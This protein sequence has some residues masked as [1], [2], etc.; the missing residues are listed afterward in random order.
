[1]KQHLSMAK[2]ERHKTQLFYL[3]VIGL[4]LCSTVQTDAQTLCAGQCGS[5]LAN[6]SCHAS[7]D[8]L[9]ICCPDYWRFCLRTSPQSGTLMGGKDFVI[10]NNTFKAEDNITC[11]FKNSI[12]T[13]GYVDDEK[14][15]HCISPLLYENGRIPFELS[16]D[17][18]K[19]YLHQGTW[20]AVHHGKYSPLKKAVLHNETKWQY[21]GTPGVTGT[22]T[23]MWNTSI[24]PQQLVRIELWGYQENGLPYSDS[25]KGVW[26]YLYSL[27][28]SVRNS[29]IFTFTPQPAQTAYLKWEI[30]MLRITGQMEPEGAP[31][32]R[33]LWSPSHALAWHLGEDF[34]GNSAAWAKDKCLKWVEL[35]KTLPDFLSE[36][37]DC[38][39]TM[40]QSRADTGRFHPDYGCDIEHGSMCTYHPGAVHCVRA[41]QGSL[42][43]G[44]GQQCCY[45][46]KGNQILTID[47]TG[48]S[49]PD[50]GHD[51]GSPPY[52][53]PPRVP[54][55]SHGLYDVIS[56]Y[57]C[58][59]W[60]DN[61]QQYTDLRP[62]SDCRTYRPP[63]V[64]TAFGDPHLFTF[65][66]T[67]FTFNGRGEYTLVTG[68]GNSTSETLQIQGRTKIIKN[69]EGTNAHVTGFAAVAMQEGDSD[70]I[71]VRIPDHPSESSVEVLVNK[72]IVT[73]NEQNWMDLKGVFLYSP[74]VHHV[75]TMFPSGA[76]VEAR[77]RGTILSITILLP[78]TFMNRTEGLFGVMNNDPNDDFTFR[79]GSTLPTDTS[80]EMLFEL[81]A[82][83]AI[84]NKSSLFT[85]DSQFLLDNYSHAPK[86][87]LNFTPVFQVPDDPS[88]PLYVDMTTLCQ[89]NEFC[90][91]DT[92]ATK[93]LQ[94]G[95]ATKLSYENY[96][97]LVESLEPVI[98]C[99]ILEE[100][101]N[102]KK[103]GNVYLIGSTLNFTC[104]E[105]HVFSGSS[106]RTCL[107]TGQWS[108]EPVYCISENVLGIV[109]G[110]LLAIFS[111][112]LIGVIL[113]MNEKRLKRKKAKMAQNSFQNANPGKI[114]M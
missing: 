46:A 95:N 30:G 31:N 3:L 62:S 37:A 83:W 112:V 14:M 91:F 96:Q 63:K 56:F 36:I 108:G 58:C 66:G 57:Y 101:K 6:C 32:V 90:R 44:A 35:E 103:R 92:L 97:M 7:C 86:H 52:E 29:G 28:K 106:M 50:R 34:R 93:S 72:E 67:N 4:I 18:G 2:G 99:G 71:E 22:L 74:I 87:D 79:N 25:W 107:P 94:L 19:N 55:F 109:L 27:V 23:L 105:G 61:C 76:G 65:D 114:D 38:P 47:S 113:Y 68:E 24:I 54:G 45:N 85:Y 26:T 49:T 110:T 100:P 88:N 11:R 69:T 21:Y 102:G 60:S 82:S 1:M 15:A 73:F 104:N 77:A 75:T 80:Q 84:E 64:G 9:G 48:G 10:V 78:E 40:E 13:M 70:L 59:L 17:D 53:R 42:K 8:P 39:C 43:Y 20:V 12:V 41:I 51:W 81:G 16:T 89:G 111:L 98:S 5:E 33:A